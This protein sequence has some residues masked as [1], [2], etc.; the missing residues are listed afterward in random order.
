MV[1]MSIQFMG[2][3]AKR[4]SDQ[5]IMIIVVGFQFLDNGYPGLAFLT[6]EQRLRRSI[7]D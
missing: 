3:R 7:K 1:A 4:S 2:E 6:I 5:I